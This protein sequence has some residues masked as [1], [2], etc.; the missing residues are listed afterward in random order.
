MKIKY[1]EDKMITINQGTTDYSLKITSN[2]FGIRIAIHGYVRFAK[3]F[4]RK[5]ARRKRDLL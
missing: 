3:T 2:T 5:V 1:A 4:Y